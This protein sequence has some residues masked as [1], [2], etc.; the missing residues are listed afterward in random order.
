[1]EKTEKKI[2]A[3]CPMTSSS[4]EQMRTTQNCYSIWKYKR[5]LLKCLKIDLF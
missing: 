4:K 1:M 3:F 5:I 2:V